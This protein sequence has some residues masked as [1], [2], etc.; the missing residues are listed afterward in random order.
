MKIIKSYYNLAK[1]GIIYG[2]LITAIAGY[3]FGAKGNID[4]SS[5][6][7]MSFGVSFVIASGCVFNNILDIKIDKKMKRTLNRELVVQKISVRSAYIYAYILGFLG[8]IVLEYFTNTITVLSGLAGLFFYVV[9]YSY[10]KRMSVHGTLIGTISGATPPVAGYFAATNSVDRASLLLF[11]VLVFWQMPHFFAIAIRRISDYKNAKIPV[12]PAV[13]GI[14]ETKL[15]I[16]VYIL[17]FIFATM[18]FS[19]FG[20]TGIV[21]TIVMLSAGFWWLYVCLYKKTK[22][23]NDWSKKVFFA[24]LIC[25]VIFDILIAFN[26]ILP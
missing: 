11:L 17:G 1:P 5:L 4:Y 25:L 3:F 2:N 14:K 24:S 6:I 12:L 20:Y 8:F 18:A 7:A 19:Y 21:Y 16:T 13:K 10:A 26:N 22:D 23:V 9:V 15:Q